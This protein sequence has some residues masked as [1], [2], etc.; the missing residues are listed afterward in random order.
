MG[1]YAGCVAVEDASGCRFEVHE[2]RRFRL[3]KLESRYV[4]DTGEAVS[5]SRHGTFVVDGT[6]ETLVPVE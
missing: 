5:L 3:L 4:L 2:Y 1:H 6:G